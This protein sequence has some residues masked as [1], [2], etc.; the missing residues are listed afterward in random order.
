MAKNDKLDKTQANFLTEAYKLRA[1]L[2]SEHTGRMWTRFNYLLT[3][4]IALF[5]FF[6]N[7]L[8]EKMPPLNSVLFPIGGIIISI[9]WYVLGTQ[10]RYYF[11]GFRV[12]TQ[13]V[14]K[15]ITN[16]LGIEQLEKRVFAKPEKVK[17]SF[18]TKRWQKISLSRLPALVPLVFL[19]LWIF[20]LLARILI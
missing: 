12:Q 10:D 8:F 19:L 11:E 16:A 4:N 2:Y 18:L 5:G 15:A 17:T 14:E 1:R 3:A 6:L 7:S 13:E 20:L 9:I